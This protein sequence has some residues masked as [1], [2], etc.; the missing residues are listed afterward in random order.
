M[1][2]RDFSI[3]FLYRSVKKKFEY[4]FLKTNHNGSPCFSI[5]YHESL[6]KKNF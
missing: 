2:K 6:K 5:S 4:K 1:E 3:V